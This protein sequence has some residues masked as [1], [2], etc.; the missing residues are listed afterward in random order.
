MEE[1]KIKEGEQ[2]E[3][4]IDLWKTMKIILFCFQSWGSHKGLKIL[5]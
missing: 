2:N 5:L 3:G 4:E 1:E